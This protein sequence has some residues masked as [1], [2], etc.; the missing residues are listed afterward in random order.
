MSSKPTTG[1]DQNRSRER[2]GVAYASADSEKLSW[3]RCLTR[4]ECDVQD[5]WIEVTWGKEVAVKG[6]TVTDCD[7]ASGIRL[8]QAGDVCD[9]NKVSAEGKKANVCWHLTKA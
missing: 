1:D 4:F 9:G 6:R 8:C 3:R 7:I 2:V 5:L